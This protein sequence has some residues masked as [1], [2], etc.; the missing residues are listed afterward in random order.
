[1]DKYF[2][3]IPSQFK[4]PF[5]PEKTERGIWGQGRGHLSAKK[6]EKKPLCPFHPL[7]KNQIFLQ[8]SGHTI[9][10]NQDRFL[11]LSYKID[12][13]TARF[14]SPPKS[15][16]PLPNNRT[17]KF[18]TSRKKKETGREKRVCRGESIINSGSGQQLVMESPFKKSYRLGL[19]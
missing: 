16:S 17:K 3:S 14:T 11:P 12:D 2:Y 10:D 1:M 6:G 13:P 19:T 8:P 18:K 9:R 15:S 5:G 7:A 4:L